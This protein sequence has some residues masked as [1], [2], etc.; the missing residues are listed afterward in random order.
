MDQIQKIDCGS[1][2][3]HGKYNDRVYLIKA[4]KES[5][6]DLPQKLINLA[7][8]YEY[9]KVFAKISRK[10]LECFRKNG[11]LIEAE[12][13]G[14]YP[15]DDG[16]F[17]GF[18]QASKRKEEKESSLYDKN[19]E[20]ALKN[21][22]KKSKPL[23]TKKFLIRPCNEGDVEKMAEIYKNI[24][25]TY[26]F[27]IH[28]PEYI[29]FTMEKNVDYFCVQVGKNIVALAS[30]E[31]DEKDLNVEMTDFATLEDWRGH[32]LGVHLLKR[33][34]AEM[35]DQGIRTAYTIARAASAGMNITFARLGYSFGG[36]LINNT[37]ISGKIESMNVWYKSLSAEKINLKPVQIA[38]TMINIHSLRSKF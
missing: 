25:A 30:A 36:R 19:I 22:N 6:A 24:F 7:R 34:E 35:K 10:Q 32:N 27:P 21:Q 14:L 33:M 17:L 20:L 26:P 9:S 23:D 8:Q 1:I 15:D 29:R 4:S 37:N 3:Q 18:Y 12:V 2:I 28:D 11:Y 16:L 13:P 5:S 38:N 31:K